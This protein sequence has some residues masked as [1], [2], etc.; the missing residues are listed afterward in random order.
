MNKAAPSNSTTGFSK[1]S[2]LK[3]GMIQSNIIVVDATIEDKS[4]LL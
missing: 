2:K 3:A 4:Y 1:Y